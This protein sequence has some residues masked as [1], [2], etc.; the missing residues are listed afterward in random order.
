MSSKISRF[1][2][3]KGDCGA[4]ASFQAAELPVRVNLPAG[5]AS[6]I[7]GLA[8]V[9]GLRSTLAAGIVIAR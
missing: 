6:G 4:L 5:S 2:G 1:A 9:I 3:Q 7:Q 8:A